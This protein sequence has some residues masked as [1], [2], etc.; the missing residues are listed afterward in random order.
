VRDPQA[1]RRC[2]AELAPTAS[3]PKDALAY[4]YQIVVRGRAASPGMS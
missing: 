3:G 4:D 1:R 2:I